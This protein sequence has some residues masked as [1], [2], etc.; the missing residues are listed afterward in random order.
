M[1]RRWGEEVSGPP[2]SL[3]CPT[4]S[5]VLWSYFTLHSPTLSVES[6]TWAGEP[7]SRDIL[8]KEKLSARQLRDGTRKSRTRDPEVQNPAGYTC[9]EVA[10][11]SLPPSV[12]PPPNPRQQPGPEPRPWKPC[13]LGAGH[14]RP[15]SRL[16]LHICP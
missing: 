7:E 15:L 16:V 2:Q 8:A 1:S 10:E 6:Q 4:G 5:D 13:Q 14:R 11:H 3:L 12:C 9:S